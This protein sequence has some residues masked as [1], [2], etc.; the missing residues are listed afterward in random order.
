MKKSY[1]KLL[2]IVLMTTFTQLTQAL[3]IE[4]N[5]HAFLKK[6]SGKSKQFVS[7]ALGKPNKVDIAVKPGNADEILSKQQV[8]TSASDKKE[9]IEMWY[10][11]AKISYAPNKNFNSAE[12]TFVNDKCV[13]ITLANKKR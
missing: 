7:Q 8:E 10:Y 13:N 6:Y 4:D 1:S 11:D 12:L 2:F 9:V 3:T 5:E